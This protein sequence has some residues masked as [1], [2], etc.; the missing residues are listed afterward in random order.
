MVPEFGPLP[1]LKGSDVWA[2]GLRR[3]YKGHVTTLSKK[4]S[5]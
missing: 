1:S 3:V 2:L 5:T 4:E